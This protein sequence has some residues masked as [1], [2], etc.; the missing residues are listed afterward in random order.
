[1]GDRYRWDPRRLGWVQARG[2][3]PWML[4]EVCVSPAPWMPEKASL[5]QLPFPSPHLPSLQSLINFLALGLHQFLGTEGRD[6]SITVLKDIQARETARETQRSCNGADTQGHLL[7]SS[8]YHGRS[9][10]TTRAPIS[11][12][13]PYGVVLTFLLP[14]CL[15]A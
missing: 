1:M 6:R 10:P 9:M 14:Q 3:K 11:F 15:S 8:L 4:V 2:R 12:L 13:P 7:G 5:H